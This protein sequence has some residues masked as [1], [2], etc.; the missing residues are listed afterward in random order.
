MKKLEDKQDL[1]GIRNYVFQKTL[2]KKKKAFC[3][4]EA[5]GKHGHFIHKFG[6]NFD[7]PYIL[8]H[9]REGHTCGNRG[10]LIVQMHFLISP[11]KQRPLSL[12]PLR[13]LNALAWGLKV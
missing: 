3:P 7:F 5:Q 9:Q 13:Y 11:R 1:E 10:L 8:W 4:E 6:D 2:K 12:S